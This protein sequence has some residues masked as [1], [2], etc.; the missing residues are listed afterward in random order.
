[1]S[2]TASPKIGG[3]NSAP[4]STDNDSLIA[5]VQFTGKNELLYKKVR[6]SLLINNGT[7]E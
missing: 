2:A 4:T 1:M 7:V 6:V 3:T 5:K